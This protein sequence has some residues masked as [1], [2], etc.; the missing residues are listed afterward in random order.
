MSQGNEIDIFEL[1]EETEYIEEIDN[2]DGLL[3]A[4]NVKADGDGF[5]HGRIAENISRT[6]EGRGSGTHGRTD[7]ISHASQH[8]SL[9]A[10]TGSRPFT[11]DEE[12]T[13][14][15][16]NSG[17]L[18]R[19]TVTDNRCLRRDKQT[20]LRQVAATT[21]KSTPKQSTM[22]RITRSQV[23][24]SAGALIIMAK[25]LS[26]ISTNGDPF[27]YAEAMQSPQRDNWRQAMNEESE[28]ILLN[29]TFTAVNSREARQLHTKPIGSKW[30]YKTK[31]N[32]DGSVR[33]KARLVIKGYEQTDFG[34]TYASVGKLTTFRYLI[35]QIGRLE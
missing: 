31:H 17:P 12:E 29:N 14:N 22:S 5:L 6:D 28:S 7:D 24:I 35:S 15:L 13:I 30:V 16:A 4:Q 8:R 26:S 11:P 10:R 21:K 9:P 1:P 34:E 3:R 32:P 25:A 33:Y 19:E 2:G 20:A 27:T 23:K 18:S